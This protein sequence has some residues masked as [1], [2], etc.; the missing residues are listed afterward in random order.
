MTTKNTNTVRYVLTQSNEIAY[1]IAQSL[2][3]KIESSSPDYIED[4]EMMVD[5][6]LEHIRANTITCIKH[7]HKLKETGDTRV[8]RIDFHGNFYLGDK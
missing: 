2:A 1:K 8:L 6:A 7:M 4:I 3:A 5:S